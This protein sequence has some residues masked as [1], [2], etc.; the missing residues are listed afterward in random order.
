[1]GVDGTLSGAPPPE[2]PALLGDGQRRAGEPGARR[3]FDPGGGVDED[4]LG[5]AGPAEELAGGAETSAPVA[6]LGVEEGFDVGDLGCRPVAFALSVTRNRARSR[7][8]PIVPSTVESARAWVP[9]RRARSRERTRCSQ[10]SATA[11][12]SGSGAPSTRRWRRPAARR[13][14]WSRPKARSWWTKKSSMV[15][16]NAPADRP[17]SRALSNSAWGWRAWPSPSRRPRPLT[18]THARPM[19]W[20][21]AAKSAKSPSHQGG[22]SS[23]AARLSAWFRAR[24]G[25]RCQQ[26]PHSPPSRLP[27]GPPQVAQG[28]ASDGLGRG[29][30]Q[31]PH[32]PVAAR[33]K[34]GRPQRGQGRFASSAWCRRRHAR[35]RTASLNLTTWPQSTQVREQVMQRPVSAESRRS[36]PQLEQAARRAASRSAAR[37]R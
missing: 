9:A 3:E 7:T 16:A 19:Q 5:P 2:Q 13:A 35:Q 36:S 11:G 32:R 24:P 23:F 29:L 28:R 15:R 30:E 20:R 14:S 18:I 33:M 17:G 1:M 12:R 22:S 34:P 25:W 31:G 27:P 37:Q 4:Q 8:W 21:S 26:R 6:R 10:N